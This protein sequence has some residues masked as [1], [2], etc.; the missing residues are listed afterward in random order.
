[1]PYAWNYWKLNGAM[2]EADYPYV[3]KVEQ[4]CATDANAITVSTV[5]NWNM[6]RD[7]ATTSNVITT[8]K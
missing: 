1:M 6:V 5:S 8:L 4:E 3:G 7:A 2:S